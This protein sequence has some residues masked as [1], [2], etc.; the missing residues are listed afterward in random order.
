MNYEH[1][2]VYLSP[3]G[4][5]RRVAERI[6]LRLEEQGRTAAIID[7]ASLDEPGRW[8]VCLADWPQHCCLWLGTPVYCDHALPQ[9]EAF[10]RS[11]PHTEVGFAVPFA[12]WGGVTSGLALPELAALLKS[13]GYQPLGAAKVMAEHSSTWRA[14]RPVASGRPAQNDLQLVDQLVDRVTAKLTAQTPVPVD[15]KT[16]DYLSPTLR[17]QAEGISLEMVKTQLPPPSIDPERCSRCGICAER[18]PVSSIALSPWPD[19]GSDCI[20]C[21]QCVRNCPEQAFP[22]DQ[23]PLY[24]RILEMAAASDERKETAIFL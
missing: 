17:R 13:Q 20:R 6:A 19:I 18:C 5:T 7:L 22:F 12:T 24:E 3:A 10:V 21:L 9:L 2:I 16:L 8:D 14:E 1:R 11:L 15:L 4:T 23:Q